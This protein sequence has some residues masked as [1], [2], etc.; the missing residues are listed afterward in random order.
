MHLLF[1]DE[2]GRLSDRRFFA[3]GGIALR[4]TDWHELRDLRQTTLAAHD[5]PAEKEVKWHGIRTGEIP[6]ALADAIVTA[7]AHAP[8]R[9]Y[10]TLLDIE[11]GLT[12]EPGFFASD[13]DTYA[14]GLMFLAERFQHLLEAEGD[15]GMIVVDSRFREEDARLRR[16]F[17]DLTHDGSPYSR[18]DRIVE[19]LFLGPSHHSIGL[20][21][22]DLVCAITTAAERGGGQARGYLKTLLPGL[23]RILRRGSSR[24]SGSSGSPSE[25]SDH[26]RSGGCSERRRAHARCGFAAGRSAAAPMPIGLGQATMQVWRPRPGP[27]FLRRDRLRGVG[28]AS[29]ARTSCGDG[30]IPPRSRSA[31]RPR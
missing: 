6:P 21:C 18:L 4:G 31:R 23:R 14:T 12:V 25:R 19:G 13:E 8:V 26:G 30:S 9:C 27:A 2:S 29:C 1:L 24:G 28:R 15:V 22:A 5:W 10:V 20:Q 11:L 3:L 17:A 16:F 7:L